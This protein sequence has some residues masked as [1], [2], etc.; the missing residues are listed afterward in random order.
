[1]VIIGMSSM[2]RLT[3]STMRMTVIVVTI[4]A[5]MM[6]K[7]CWIMELTVPLRA[8]SVVIVTLTTRYSL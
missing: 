8:I 2:M 7:V 6:R 1:M 4:M 5:V 3:T